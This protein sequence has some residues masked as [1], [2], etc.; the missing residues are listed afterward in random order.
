MTTKYLFERVTDSRLDL[1]KSLLDVFAEVFEEPL[2]YLGAIPGDQYL[3]GLLSR[4]DFVAL[5]A[6]AGEEVVG[7]LVAY[8]LCK[9]EQERSEI[10]V[11]DLGVRQHHRRK[12]VA[13]GLIRELR[14]I[15]RERRAWVI[16]VQADAVDEAAIRLYE[17]LGQGEAVF[18][19]DI[20]V[21]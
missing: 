5:V 18:N 11:Y 4:D 9:F 12:G 3:R 14:S 16:F 13:T 19:F 2:T 6:L 15:A 1:M 20:P 8:E 21:G 7:G 10:Y 17:S